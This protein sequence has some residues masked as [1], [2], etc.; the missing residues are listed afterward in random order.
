V[1][2]TSKHWLSIIALAVACGTWS[3]PAIACEPKQRIDQPCLC[4]EGEV[5][6]GITSPTGRAS[7]T[8]D[9]PFDAN[10]TTFGPGAGPESRRLPLPTENASMKSVAL[11]LFLAFAWSVLRRP[12]RN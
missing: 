12:K 10:A 6:Q 5:A 1:A 2:G 11:A 9:V 3:P 8:C 7:L 4:T